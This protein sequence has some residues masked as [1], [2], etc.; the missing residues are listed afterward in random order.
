MEPSICCKVHIC[1]SSMAMA[2]HKDVELGNLEI[3]TYTKIT[4]TL[5]GGSSI[6]IDAEMTQTSMDLKVSICRALDL[7]WD[8]D[9]VSLVSADG[10]ELWT[11]ADLLAQRATLQSMGLTNGAVVMAVLGTSS[12]AKK[13][14]RLIAV[15]SSKRSDVHS[16]Q[17]AA[18]EL[19]RLGS[20]SVPYAMSGLIDA[21]QDSDAWVKVYAVQALG[22]SEVTIA[23]SQ[24][25]LVG[26][27]LSNSDDNLRLAVITALGNFGQASS[28]FSEAISKDLDS[29]SWK[30][31]AAAA[32]A[33]GKIG[34]S[35]MPYLGN[36]R[37]LSAKRFLHSTATRVVHDAASQAFE[38]LSGHPEQSKGRHWLLQCPT[39]QEREED[40]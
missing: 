2:D 35:S 25:T 5:L 1:S 7:P 12:A 22:K 33:L 34:P 31:V 4:V 29:P 6:D 39:R 36:L 3:D 15:L 21:C 14:D 24:V 26:H 40:C 38:H 20:A 11:E 30:I 19:M 28:R 9:V 8:R 32:V 13:A 18:R 16:R 27:L 23:S 17:Q 37:R 10:V